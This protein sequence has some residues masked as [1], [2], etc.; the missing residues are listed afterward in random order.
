MTTNRKD[1]DGQPLI[2]FPSQAHNNVCKSLD[3]LV[4]ICLGILADQ[5]V[6]DEEAMNFRRWVQQLYAIDCGWPLSDVRQR[7]E[8][9]FADGKIDDEERVELGALMRQLAGVPE[10]KIP[11]IGAA[12][13]L[14]LDEPPPPIIFPEKLFVVTGKFAHGTRTK[15]HQE[16]ETRG[17]CCGKAPTLDTNYLVIGAFASRDWIHSTHGLKIERAIELRK[18]ST[19]IA[20]IH[21][22][23]WRTFIR[24]LP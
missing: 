17:G 6:N 10:E 3:Q 24:V 19:G 8:Q 12:T 9:I 13:R 16:I 21:E 15:V 23:H 18:K 11:D 7:V 4:G 22:E 20:I 14:P 2:P 5:V 1:G